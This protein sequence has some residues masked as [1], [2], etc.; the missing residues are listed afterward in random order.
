MI[1]RMKYWQPVAARTLVAKRHSYARW[2]PG[3]VAISE[4]KQPS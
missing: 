4:C 3:H 2:R 1:L